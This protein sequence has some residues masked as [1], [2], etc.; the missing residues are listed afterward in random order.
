MHKEGIHDR[1]PPLLSVA[2]IKAVDELDVQICRVNI[3]AKSCVC[4]YIYT[5]IM[6]A[7]QSRSCFL[8]ERYRTTC[9][10]LGDGARKGM[11][12]NFQMRAHVLIAALG[13]LTG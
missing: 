1:A 7:I 8:A 10:L 12:A 3:F 4:V 9:K 11:S 6:G 2:L 5:Y 13:I